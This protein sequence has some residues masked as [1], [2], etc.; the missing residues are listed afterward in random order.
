MKKTIK[1]RAFGFTLIELLVVIAIIA[2]LAALLLPALAKA[3]AKASQT[4][5]VN[6]LK[7]TCLSFV[8]WVN[9]RDVN[10][11][12]ARTPW[13]AGGTMPDGNDPWGGGNK[14]GVAW[15][16]FAV[17]SNE[18][19]SPQ[20]LACPGDK[21][22]RVA[23]SWRIDDPA[24]GF[25]HGNFRDNGLSYFINMDC[26][27][28]NPGGGSTVSSFEYAQDQVLVGDQNIRYDALATG[29]SAKVNN[30]AR[31]QT[32]RS[33]SWGIGTWTNSIHGNKGNLGVVDGSVES[34]VPSSF[35]ELVSLADDNGSVHFLPPR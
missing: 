35:R 9:D 33:G 28:R 2:I 26:G 30:V 24:G 12:P 16:E 13:D 1:S 18:L 19:A 5:C 21:E 20:I 10:N 29:C 7:Q 6:N 32:T 31:L 34:T 17:V 25:T 3:K 8:M 23:T 11:L 22:A 27:T 4:K 15:F 14:P